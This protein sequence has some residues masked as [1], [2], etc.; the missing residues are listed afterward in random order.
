MQG[1]TAPYSYIKRKIGEVA[2]KVILDWYEITRYT[3][4]NFQFPQ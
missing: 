1:T 4:S 3:P 2:Q